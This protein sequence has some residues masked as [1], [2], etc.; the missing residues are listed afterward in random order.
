[1][2]PDCLEENFQQICYCWIQEV[3]HV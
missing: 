2:N 3:L 1:M